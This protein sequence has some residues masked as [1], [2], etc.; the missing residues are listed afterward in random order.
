MLNDQINNLLILKLHIFIFLPKF[1]FI[2]SISFLFFQTAAGYPVILF[3]S[4][5][6]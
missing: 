4:S 2:I 6:L 5:H 1:H 3:F